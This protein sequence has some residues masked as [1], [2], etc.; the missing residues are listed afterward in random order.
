MRLIDLETW[1]PFLLAIQARETVEWV[2]CS[3]EESSD[4]AVIRRRNAHLAWA[5]SRARALP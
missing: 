3:N 1:P 2:S 5:L 4:V